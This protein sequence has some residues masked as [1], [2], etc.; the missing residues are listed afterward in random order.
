[1]GGSE[2]ETERQKRREIRI[3]ARAIGPRQE[4]E[5]MTHDKDIIVL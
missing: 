1:M 3:T 4:N 2:T 5:R